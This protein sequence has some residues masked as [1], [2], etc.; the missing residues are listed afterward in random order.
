MREQLFLEVEEEQTH[1]RTRD[2]IAGHELRVRE[3]LVD[4]F[5]DNV[6]LIQNQIALNKDGHLAIG[7]HYRDVFGLVEQIYIADFKVH[8][9]FKKH[10]TAALREGA[11][12]ARI[13]NH[14]DEIFLKRYYP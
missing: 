10:E 9:F 12:G 2:W 1:A 13:Q 3:A 4:V 5:I 11:S 6:G 14:H 7:V 8:A